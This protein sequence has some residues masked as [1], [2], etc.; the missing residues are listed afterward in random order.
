MAPRVGPRVA[1]SPANLA[2]ANSASPFWLTWSFTTPWRRD[3][4]EY[5][6]FD[7]P[8]GPRASAGSSEGLAS[9]APEACCISRR[10]NLLRM[11]PPSSR[12][13]SCGSPKNDNNR[14]RKLRVSGLRCSSIAFTK[15]A[16]RPSCRK[17]M[18]FPRPQSGAVRNSF[19]LLGPD[20][21]RHRGL[22]P[23]GEPQDPN[24]DLH[25]CPTVAGSRIFRIVAGSRI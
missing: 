20:L 16:V 5:G 8:A 19:F 23:S 18:R 21:C 6:I 25:L 10:R 14:Q 11:H 17:K 2:Q 15:S 1:A 12:P 9:L 24:K 4:R 13:Q 3:N 7:S 22:H